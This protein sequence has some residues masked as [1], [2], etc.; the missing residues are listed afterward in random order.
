MIPTYVNF[1]YGVFIN[2]KL[3]FAQAVSDS[4]ARAHTENTHTE[5]IVCC[6]LC[7]L[8]FYKKKEIQRWLP[9]VF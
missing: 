1:I 8:S 7:N 3:I 5:F 9:H 2:H 6:Y 4:L